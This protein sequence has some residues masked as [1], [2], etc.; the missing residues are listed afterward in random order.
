V[1]RGGCP[2]SRREAK[3]HIRY[4]DDGDLKRLH[5]EVM[6]LRLA[7]FRYRQNTSRTQLGFIIDDVERARRSTRAR[8][9]RS[10]RLHEH[11]GGGAPDPGARDRGAQER[12]AQAPAKIEKR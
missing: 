7:R 11:G 1:Q 8:H 9:G 5:D 3:D 4:L 2:I 10:L 6:R 12:G